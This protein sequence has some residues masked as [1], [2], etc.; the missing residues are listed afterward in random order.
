MEVIRDFIKEANLPSARHVM[1]GVWASVCVPRSRSLFKAE[2]IAI[3]TLE[4]TEGRRL[5]ERRWDL[6]LR[7]VISNAKRN[8][9]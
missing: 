5:G 9:V 2:Q 1:C 8:S 3:V 7:G 6:R 4:R